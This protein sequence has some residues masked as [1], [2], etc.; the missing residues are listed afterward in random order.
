MRLGKKKRPAC[1]ITITVSVVD[2][3]TAVGNGG[4]ARGDASSSNSNSMVLQAYHHHHHILD[5]QLPSSS[6][7]S[8]LSSSLERRSGKGRVVWF[9]KEWETATDE[10]VMKGV[11]AALDSSWID[12]IITGKKG[13]GNNAEQGDSSNGN[14]ASS[15]TGSSSSGS[16]DEKHRGETKTVASTSVADFFQPGEKR[17]RAALAAEYR[18]NVN[19]KMRGGEDIIL[20][21]E[22]ND[23]QHQIQ[24][25]KQ[26][27]G[28]I[29]LCSD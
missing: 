21:A 25:K 5:I 11:I 10:R 22:Q 16:S 28:V 6:S 12:P 3:D 2:D 7:A 27:E 23:G 24:R 8:S 14:N 15:S 20:R 17:K 13:T 19:G 29:D 26:K 9:W 4:D 18:K 1:K